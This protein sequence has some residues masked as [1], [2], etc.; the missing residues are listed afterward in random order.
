VE[1]AGAGARLPAPR[2]N[3]GRLRKAVRTA[4]GRRDGA[5]RMAQA[6]ASAGGAPAAADAFE[7]LLREA[8]VA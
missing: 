6:F 2:L 7:S 3:A 4:M 1:V 5:A 8:A